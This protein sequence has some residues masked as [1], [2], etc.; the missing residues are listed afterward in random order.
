MQANSSLIFGLILSLNLT[1]ITNNNS[2]EMNRAIKFKGK[3]LDN[4]E[5]IYGDLL[6][7][8]DGVYISNDNGCNMAQV[9][10]DTVGQYTGL[11]DKNGKEIYE[12]DILAH[13]GKNIG[14]V[15]NDMRCYC[16]DLVCADTASTSTLSLHAAV[17]N[18]HE[19]DIEIIGNINDPVEL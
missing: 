16:F 7:L 18:D 15:A 6:H 8:V 10:P 12:D 2:T 13:N 14:Y 19:G 1:I 17:V 4:G 11:K 5:W 3:R 9:Y